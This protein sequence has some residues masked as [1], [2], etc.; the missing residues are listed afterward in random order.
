MSCS[1]TDARRALALGDHQR[2]NVVVYESPC[3]VEDASG[4]PDGDDVMALVLKDFLDLHGYLLETGTII[5]SV[6]WRRE[7]VNAMRAFALRSLYPIR[8]RAQTP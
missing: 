3:S 4:F 7:A 1:V 8:S 2:A 5:A 6:I